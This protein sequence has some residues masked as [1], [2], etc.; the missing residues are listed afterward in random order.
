MPEKPR[1]EQ[2]IAQLT[3]LL[4]IRSFALGVN[5]RLLWDAVKCPKRVWIGHECAG[6]PGLKSEHIPTSPNVFFR[7]RSNL[8]VFQL[9]YLDSDMDGIMGFVHSVRHCS[10]QCL[11]ILKLSQGKEQQSARNIW[12]FIYEHMPLFQAVICDELPGHLFLHRVKLL[13][14]QDEQGLNSA[15]SRSV[16]SIDKLVALLRSEA[17]MDA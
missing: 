14:Y 13:G 7:T 15:Y 9:V 10:E 11:W 1:A 5:D 2:W 3:R 16:S 8:P 12:T 6:V 4:D 17:G